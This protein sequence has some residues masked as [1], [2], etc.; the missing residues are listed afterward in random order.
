MKLFNGKIQ[1]LNI[2]DIQ[3]TLFNSFNCDLTNNE[4]KLGI[5]PRTILTTDT[6]SNMTT[7]VA[8]KYFDTKW[9]A[10][11]GRV[12]LNDGTPIGTFAEDSSSGVPTAVSSLY[13]DMEVFGDVLLVA[14]TAQLYSKALVGGINAGTGAYTSRRTFA[15]SGDSPTHMLCVYNQRAYW[16]DTRGQIFSMNTAFSTV[17]TTAATYTFKVPD[18][19]DIVWMRPHS[20]GM[21]I[22]TSDPNGGNSY[23]YDWDGITANKWNFRYAVSAQG[24][25]SGY[26]HTDGLLYIVT[27]DSR[28]MQLTGAGFVMINRLPIKKN[29]LYKANSI[30]VN[31]RFIHPNGL[32]AI[33]GNICML[34][35]NRNN[36]TTA[37]SYMD[38]IHSGIWEYTQATGLN[39][40]YALSYKTPTSVITDYGQFTLNLAGAIANVGDIYTTADSAK[41]NFL[42]GASYFTDA[43]TVGYGIWTDS[44]YDEVEKAGFFTTVQIRAEHF[45]QMWNKITTILNPTDNNLFVIKY[46]TI[47]EEPVYFDITWTSQ[48]TFT[49]TEATLA[50]G[51]EI[52]VI[53]GKG[54]GRCAHV[55]SVTGS[56][57]VTLDQSFGIMSG[58][59]K[60]RREN[61]KKKSTVT[62]TSRRFDEATI[63]QPDTWVELKV[64]MLGTGENVLVEDMVLD[65]TK[66][67]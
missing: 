40:K 57:T 30:I 11:G 9:F 10:L 53:Q 7:P 24:V 23:V 34:I 44:Y 18:G 27:S 6:L 15:I 39:H 65:N 48:K 36:S 17:T 52:T 56:Y 63:S 13:S 61:W 12:F 31:D 47:R 66:Q 41:G 8:F 55:T 43:T 67:T 38:N 35:N 5:A 62:S 3:G 16:V 19:Q 60:A 51:D 46:R 22:G 59:A 42:A 50:V 37:V 28:L 64:F 26:V 14:G 29:L 25:L 32:T 2:G 21:Y 58:T 33:N 1:Q 4:G 45:E 49:T 20:Q 54:S